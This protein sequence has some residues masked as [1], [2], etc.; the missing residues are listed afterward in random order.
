MGVLA[1]L[2]LLLVPG[3]RLVLLVM[4]RVLVLDRRFILHHAKDDR[5]MLGMT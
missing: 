5:V 2:R 4:V 3:R 1:L